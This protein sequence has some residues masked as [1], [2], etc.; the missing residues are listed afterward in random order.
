MSEHTKEPWRI[1]HD[2]GDEYYI[3]ATS[4]LSGHT[5]QLGSG[6]FSKDDASRIVACVNACEG[7]STSLLERATPFDTALFFKSQRDELLAALVKIE[8]N[9]LDAN[10]AAIARSAIANAEKYGA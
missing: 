8:R 1:A 3:E 7:I 5:C 4:R 9:T 6:Y 10:M 2:E